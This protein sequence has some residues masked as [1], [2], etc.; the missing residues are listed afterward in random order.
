[1]NR[2]A[3]VTGATG[4]IGYHL[5]ARLRDAGWVVRAVVRPQSPK[6]LPL[7]VERC[8]AALD[9]RSLSPVF[10]D[11]AVV[12][13]L[14]GTTRAVDRAA[15]EVVNVTA[16]QAVGL[17]ARQAGCRL[18]LVSSQAAAGPGSA[19][20]PR[21]E[22][23]P[24]AP[25]CAYG[26][27]KLAGERQIRAIDGLPWVIV[28]PSA[29]YGPRDRDFPLFFRLAERGIFPITGRLDD[30]YSFLYVD[31]LT[32]ALAEVAISDD[33][34]GEVFFATH[35]ESWSNE[36]FM[37]QL[38]ATV[39]R[40]YRPRRLPRSLLWLVMTGG[41]AL[42]RLGFDPALTRCRYLQMQAGGYVCS[43]EKLRRI[44][45]WEAQVGLPEGLERTLRWY[46]DESSWRERGRESDER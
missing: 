40:T 35:P 43:P 12:I 28:R 34:V 30:S 5:C 16:T 6:P 22:G 13:H 46:T 24:E 7:G 25:I 38:A 9:E 1:M 39:E 23:D 20:R 29:V 41:R 8:P 31:D 19:G 26:R 36:R 21:T 11:A 17:A 44:A 27:S 37:A 45:G 3:A 2:I 42:A 14:A 32:R 15:Y 10:R 18:V 4:F 33:C